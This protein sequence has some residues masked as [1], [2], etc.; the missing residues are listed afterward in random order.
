MKPSQIKAQ[1]KK[2]AK[3]FDLKYNPEWFN[4][5]WITTRQ[6]ILT[7][8]IGDC[9]DPI[10]MKYGKT[11]NERIKN[12]DKFVNSK[13]FKSCLKRVGGQVTSR[14][15][16]KKELKWFK[17]IEDISLR[18]ELLK[19]HYQIK[20]KLDKTE[21]LALLTKTKIIK[22]KKWMM[23]HCL[24]HEWIHIL[25]DKNKVQFQEIN[26]KYWPYDEGI[27]EY[28]GCYLDGTLSKLEKFRDKETYP[29]EHKNWVYAIKLRELLKEK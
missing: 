14:K 15:E 11:P 19:L 3:E 12:I 13:D 28:L 7:E 21:H 18:N 25:L 9:P 8:Y 16:W 29:M 27:N 24:R 10:Y 1:I 23:T 6:E 22:W 17:K 2:L 26:K 20:K 5:M 4:F